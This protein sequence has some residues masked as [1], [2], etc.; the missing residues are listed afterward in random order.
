TSSNFLQLGDM[1]SLCRINDHPDALA[2]LEGHRRRRR[3]TQGG[4]ALGWRHV[5]VPELA[6]VSTLGDGPLDCPGSINAWRTRELDALWPYRQHHL[7][8]CVRQRRK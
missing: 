1:N 8:S 5:I 4:P 7:A 2:D 6:E 3:H